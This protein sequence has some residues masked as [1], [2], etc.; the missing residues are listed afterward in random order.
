M[1]IVRVF[2]Q[3]LLECVEEPEMELEIEAPMNVRDLLEG[4]AEKMGP[5]IEF[6]HKSELMI[7]VNQKIVT[8]DS[9]VKDG[10]QIKLTHQ[11][12]PE[13]EGMMWHNP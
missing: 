9:M 12:N 2:G 13:L 11:F 6:L 5:L 7:T 1:V 4:Q 10:D 3:N 8:L